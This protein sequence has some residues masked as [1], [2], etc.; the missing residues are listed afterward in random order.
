MVSAVG[1]LLVPSALVTV[2]L[3]DRRLTELG[4]GDLSVLHADALVVTAGMLSA[5]MFDS[6]ANHDATPAVASDGLKMTMRKPWP[7][8]MICEEVGDE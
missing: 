8:Q 6:S 2:V 7:R 3:F 1:W 4:R 5:A